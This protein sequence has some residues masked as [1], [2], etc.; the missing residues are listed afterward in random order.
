MNKIKL[1]LLSLAV[2]AS[3][4]SYSQATSWDLD[5][6]DNVDALTDGLLL[7]RHGFDLRGEGLTEG[8]VASDSS[9]TPSQIEARIVSAYT[10]A[11]IDQSGEVDA[12][13]DGLLLL[14]YLFDLRGESLIVGAVANHGS[15]T[16]SDAIEQYIVDHM[17]SSDDGSDNSGD[18]GSGDTGSGDTGSGDIGG[19]NSGIAVIDE[20]FGGAT[21]QGEIFTFPTGAE[22]WAGFANMNLDL[23]PFTFSNGGSLSFKGS[24][25]S[26]GSVNIRFRFEYN[27]HPDVDPAYDTQTVTVSG[28]DENDYSVSIPSQGSNTFS[29]LIMYV[30]D[31]D[32]PVTVSN[33]VVSTNGGSG[34]SGS[35][36][37]GSSDT[38]SGD[39]GSGDTGSGDTGAGDTGA[40]DTGSGDVGSGDRGEGDSG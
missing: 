34:D 25:P 27:P 29:N 40:G 12:L 39:T 4:S 23:Y 19:T 20:A 33:V 16:T 2:L 22:P 24:V 1:Y 10:I 14:R 15:R 8:A 9:L 26:G 36:D 38:G 3:F 37:T 17:T 21:F 32:A 11:D 7:L 18:T 5:G 30:V 6:N 13:T 35:S 31:R 28:A